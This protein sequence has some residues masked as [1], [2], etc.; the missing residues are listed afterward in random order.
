MLILD[1]AIYICGV[2]VMQFYFFEELES[3]LNV[4]FYSNIL[5]N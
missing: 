4:D 2:K 5:N 3:V 1:T